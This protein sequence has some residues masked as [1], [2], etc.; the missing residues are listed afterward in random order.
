MS[1]WSSVDDDNG[2]LDQ[3]LGPHQL[4]VGGV[5]DHVDDPGLACHGLAAPGEV[6]S[7]QS[8]G[9][10]LLV[11]SSSTNSVDP[12]RSELGHGW[13]SGQLK[14]PLL[15]D[16]VPLASGGSALVPVIS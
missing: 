2:V 10:V 6:A 16:L 3:S 9:S 12:L 11:S 5:V 8:Q 1:E 7:V 14:L 13:R 15:A 4:V